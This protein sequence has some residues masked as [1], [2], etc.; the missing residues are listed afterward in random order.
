MTETIAHTIGFNHNGVYI[1]TPEQLSAMFTPINKITVEIILDH[2]NNDYHQ[3]AKPDP[4]ESRA[5]LLRSPYAAGHLAKL[6]EPQRSA[7][8]L[9]YCGSEIRTNSEIADKLGISEAAVAKRIN[10]GLVIFFR[11]CAGEKI[12]DIRKHT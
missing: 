11:L 2:A 4:A 6:S 5:V 3:I 12:N 7:L 1:G 9:K 10:R 8:E